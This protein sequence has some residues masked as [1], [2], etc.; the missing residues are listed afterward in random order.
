MEKVKL[1][2]GET[3]KNY[4]LRAVVAM[5]EQGTGILDEIHYDDAECDASCLI[6]DLKFEFRIKHIK[7]EDED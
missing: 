1:Q 7:D 2:K 5:L 4:L 3:R 6:E